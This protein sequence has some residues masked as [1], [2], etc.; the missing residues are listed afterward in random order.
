[1]SGERDVERLLEQVTV[2][3]LRE[4]PHRER[5]KRELL[6]A[7]ERS[8][9]NGEEPMNANGRLRMTRLMKLAAGVLIAALLVATGWAAEKV[10]Q[11]VT[12]SY[13]VELEKYDGSPVELPDG[14]DDANSSMSVVSVV[15]TTIPDNAPPGSAEKVKR[16]HEVMKRLIAEKKYKFIETFEIP[17]DSQT[18]YAYR[19]TL[20][21]GEHVNMNFSMRLEDVASWEEYLQKSKEQLR[22]RN[23]QISKAI[24]AGKFRLLDVEPL[25]T[26]VC[27]DVDVSQK[28]LVQRIELPDGKE[29]ALVRGE[30]AAVPGYQT[31]WQDHLQAVRQGERVLLDLQ[32][33]EN[34]TYEITLDDGSTTIFTYAGSEPLKKRH[35]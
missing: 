4:G 10:Y 22:Q 25:A 20:P 29:I 5:L 35:G 31:S 16:N 13:Y 32:V 7:T 14:R 26:H 21:D 1:M 9:R 11:K 8:R 2:P 18:Q 24:A 23:E 27:R 19:F 15:G 3:T 12:K 33:S 34:Y 28:L 17:P 30:T 6:D